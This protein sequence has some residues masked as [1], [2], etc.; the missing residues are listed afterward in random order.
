MQKYRVFI[1]HKVK[2]QK[3]LINK[4]L[5]FVAF[6]RSSIIVYEPTEP[7]IIYVPHFM[8]HQN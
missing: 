3:R 4:T 5:K 6:L 7:S 8:S 2:H 1:I